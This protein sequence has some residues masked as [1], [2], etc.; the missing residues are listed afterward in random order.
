MLRSA[1]PEGEY[2]RFAASEGRKNDTVPSGPPPKGTASYPS[3]ARYRS[4][5]HTP[6]LHSSFTC[7]TMLS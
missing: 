6:A 7:E 3:A 2:L 5:L 1:R 4:R